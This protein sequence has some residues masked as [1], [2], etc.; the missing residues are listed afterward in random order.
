MRMMIMS[1]NFYRASHRAQDRNK[2]PEGEG[3]QCI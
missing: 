1:P 2:Q 3:S